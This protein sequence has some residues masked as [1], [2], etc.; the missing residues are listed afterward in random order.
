MLTP[1]TYT[2]VV[3][4]QICKKIF[5]D[6]LRERERMD[7]KQST[8][9]VLMFP[10]LAH[11]HISPFLELA[12]KLST[13]NFKIYLC[14]T[15]I[16]LNGIK[17]RLTQK[18]THSIKLVELHVPVLP[19]LPPQYHTTKN[20][21][22]NLMPILKQALDL[23]EPIFSHILKTLK[24]DLLIYDLIQPWW[25]LGVASSYNIPAVDFITSS[26]IMTVFIHNLYKNP[27][28]K[29]PFQDS[30][31][32]REYDKLD[33]YYLL[34]PSRE[35]FGK[36]DTHSSP[37]IILIKTFKEVEGKYM[38]SLSRLIGKK[39]LPLPLVQDC[40]NE[41]DYG[42]I[43]DWLKR[44][45]KGSTV[46]VSFGTEYFLSEHQMEE[47]ALGLELS[48]VN[49]IWILRFPMGSNTSVER[50]LPLGFLERVGE[51]GLVVEGW[52]PQVKILRHPSVGGFVSHCGW[53]STMEAMKYGTPIIAIPMQYDQPINARLVEEI[54]V[55]VEVVRDNNGKLDRGKVG[56]VI[57]NVVQFDG[58]GTV[59]KKARELS[60]TLSMKGEEDIDVLVEELL[61]LYVKKKGQM[62]VV[63]EELVKL[64][65]KKKGQ[66]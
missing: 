26:V 42:G 29:I 27:L 35:T 37:D 46:F 52:A 59:R 47:I 11:G 33:V 51:R 63:V 8:I 16:N 2:R 40:T 36:E 44:K 30:I 17:P 32:L 25:G 20:L 14:S 45:E 56:Q 66:E 62:D 22:P 21:P 7:A 5:K 12:K 57:K 18:Y 31:Y 13:R 4:S 39:I 3:M 15:P 38:D 23:S 64:Y 55:G 10:W 53:G 50:A 61:K 41:D 24:P 58:E 60:E 54:G 43:I 1:S 19:D 9:S 34:N 6:S 65:V 49:F 28:T 48:G